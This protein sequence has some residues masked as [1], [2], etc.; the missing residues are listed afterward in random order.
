MSEETLAERMV[1]IET[2]INFI[3]NSVERI[4][5]MQKISDEKLD[6]HV[7]WEE[8]QKY[9]EL[10]KEFV[11]KIHFEK[12][13][14]SLKEDIEELDQDIERLSNVMKTDFAGIWVESWVKAFAFVMVASIVT[15][16]IVGYIM[17]FD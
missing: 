11:N 10:Q 2:T 9:P 14:K 5:Q 8:R 3:A 1:K 15:G 13:N 7:E 12:E 17:K 6:R 16:I 4:E